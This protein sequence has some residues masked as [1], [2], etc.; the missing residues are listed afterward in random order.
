MCKSKYKNNNPSTL[1]LLREVDKMV[2][3]CKENL[4]FF[5]PSL[6][7]EI[8]ITRRYLIST[9]WGYCPIIGVRK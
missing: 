7:L 8:A 4:N 6:N 1:Y 3:K 9:S 5:E 2:T